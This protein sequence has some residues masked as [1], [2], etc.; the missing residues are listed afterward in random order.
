MGDNAIE[1]LLMPVFREMSLNLEK[2]AQ[3]EKSALAHVQIHR[4]LHALTV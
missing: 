1:V 4:C 3:N 2:L